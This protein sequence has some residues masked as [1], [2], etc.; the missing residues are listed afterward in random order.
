MRRKSCLDVENF[1]IC[2]KTICDVKQQQERDEV[3][4][5]NYWGSSN[6]HFKGFHGK[7]EK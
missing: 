4:N 1:K 6:K 5:F 3:N 2:C 7:K